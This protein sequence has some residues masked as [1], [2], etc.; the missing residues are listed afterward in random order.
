[1]ICKKLVRK[2]RRT[3]NVRTEEFASLGETTHHVGGQR[4]FIDNGAHILG[5]A[6]LDA[7]LAAPCIASRRHAACPQLDDRL[8]V[9]VLL[10]LLPTLDCPPFDVL[11]TDG[12]ESGQ[13]TAQ[14]FKQPRQYNWLFSFDREGGTTALYDYGGGDFEK[15]V[16]SYNLSPAHGTYSDICELDDLGAKA[17]NVGTG[18]KNQHSYKCFANLEQTEAMARRFV[19]FAKERHE[20]HMPH[21][22]RKYSR[23][24]SRSDPWWQYLAEERTAIIAKPAKRENPKVEEMAYCDT[25]RATMEDDAWSYCPWCGGAVR[26][27]YGFDERD[28]Y[29]TY[30]PF[31]GA[32]YDNPLT[33]EE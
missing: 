21:T 7:V 18:Y 28:G 5:V 14:G 19:R 20:E 12:E 3:C 11:L 24:P 25:C 16:K 8:G 29:A 27:Q 26:R 15:L 30:R 33:W 6:H 22:R 17:M 1:M 9:F 32:E 10:H 4:V 31:D 2:L 13:S 23:I